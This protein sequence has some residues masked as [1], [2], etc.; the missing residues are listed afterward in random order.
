[1]T[2]RADDIDAQYMFPAA[3]R[4]ECTYRFTLLRQR[5]RGIRD[6]LL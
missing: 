2:E 6:L 5:F 4:H 3:D 1:L